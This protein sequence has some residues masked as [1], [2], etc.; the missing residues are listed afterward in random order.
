MFWLGQRNQAIAQIANVLFVVWAFA[1]ALTVAIDLP[2]VH[3]DGAFQTASGLYR[4]DAGQLPGKDFFPYLGVGPLML[5]YPAF[6]LAGGNL[7]ASVFS[8][9]FATLMLGWLSTA[10]LWRMLF[11]SHSFATALAAGGALF[12]VPFT[13]VRQ[14]GWHLNVYVEGEPLDPEVVGLPN[15]FTVSE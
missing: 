6:K 13:D 12:V 8:A 2:V 7:A 15:L 10:I 14:L 5:L 11:R 4:L 3:L 9:H 1:S